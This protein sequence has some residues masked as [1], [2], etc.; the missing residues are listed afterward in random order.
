MSFRCFAKPD[1]D[2]A[3]LWSKE[4]LTSEVWTLAGPIGT[5]ESGSIHI[6]SEAGLRGAC[7]PAFGPDGTPRAAH[8]KIAADLA[9]QLKLS[10]PACSLWADPQSGGHYSISAWAFDQA[11][12]W[13]EVR[14]NL[15]LAFL[16]SA[17][18]A[19]SAARVFHTWIDDQDHNGNDGNVIVDVSSSDDRPGVAFIDHAFSMSR[20]PNFASSAVQPLGVHY[21][22]Q[23]LSDAEAIAKMISYINELEASMIED[24]VRRVPTQFLPSERADGIIQGLLSRRPEL[25]RVFGVGSV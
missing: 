8:E 23:D 18:P 14:A 25:L 10:V 5:G 12:K 15:T 19:F 4:T 16:Q 22:P 13:G 6:M 24:I 17:A 2:V 3:D 21:V 20:N 1:E 7:K 11:M 9:Y